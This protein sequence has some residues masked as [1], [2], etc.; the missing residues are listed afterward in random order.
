MTF[1]AASAIVADDHELFRAALAE[2]LRREF[3]FGLVIEAGSLDDAVDLLGRTSNVAFASIDL[4]MPGMNG[5]A[6]L[7]SIREEYP[8]I[9]LAVITGS[10]R[11]DDILLALDAGVHGYIPKTLKIAEIAAA[12]RTILEGRIFVPPV[13]ANKA[14]PSTRRNQVAPAVPHAPPRL[15]GLSP[16]QRAV[17]DLISLGKSNKEIAHE[18]RL[19]EGTVKVHVSAL[20]R[21]LGTHNRMGAVAAIARLHVKSARN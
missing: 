2:I 18:L 14:F 21:T 8:D 12:L 6:S 3:G 1:N 17:L 13:L 10:E 7:L 9:R 20:F 11:R 19:A 5:E 4:A 16:R 15:S